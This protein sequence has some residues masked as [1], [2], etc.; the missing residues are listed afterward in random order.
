MT[1]T[2]W[3]PKGEKPPVMVPPGSTEWIKPWF[4]IGRSYICES[5]VVKSPE[6]PYNTEGTRGSE[7]EL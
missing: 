3:F 1:M 5:Q 2:G 6:K 4:P 7:D